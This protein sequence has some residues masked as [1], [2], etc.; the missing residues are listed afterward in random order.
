MQ[1]RSFNGML[2]QR[3]LIG[4]SGKILNETPQYHFIYSLM[5]EDHR[6]GSNQET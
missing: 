6:L 5:A 2:F 4:V 1:I 3:E